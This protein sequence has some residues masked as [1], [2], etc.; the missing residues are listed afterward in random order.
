MLKTCSKCK[1][2][3]PINEFYL[4]NEYSRRYR[5]QCKECM[6]EYRENNKEKIAEYKKEYRLTNKEKI[7]EY[8]KEYCQNNKE[9]MN[10][11]QRNR[12]KIDP[13]YKLNTNIRNAIGFSLHG[14][15][16]GRHWED[17]VG[18]TLDE[19]KKHLEKQFTDG[20]NWDN[21]GFWHLDH[22]I[23]LSAFNFTKPKHIGFKIAWALENLQPLWAEENMSKNAKLFYDFQSNLAI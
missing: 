16:N 21:Y 9:K 19:L 1:K 5:N 23:P 17:L 4:R 10:E 15:K 18:Y 3:K 20:M 14:N 22:R 6:K 11:H 13:K 2:T 7:A 12:R 8:H